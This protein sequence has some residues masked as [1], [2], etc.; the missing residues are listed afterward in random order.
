MELQ[1]EG[2]SDAEAAS[3]FLSE[4]KQNCKGSLKLGDLDETSQEA[5]K[6]IRKVDMMAEAEDYRPQD[7][8]GATIGNSVQQTSWLLWDIFEKASVVLAA[9]GADLRMKD[10]AM[11]L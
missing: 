2:Y 7:N 5:R 8:S 6:S 3:R 4:L 1:H 9:L 11:S 10:E